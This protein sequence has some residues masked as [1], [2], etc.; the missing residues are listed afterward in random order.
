MKK[1][2][3]FMAVILLTGSLFAQQLQVSPKAHLQQ[4]QSVNTTRATVAT[5]TYSSDVMATNIGYGVPQVLTAV[6]YFPAATMTTYNGNYINQILIGVDPASL[7]SVDV[8]IWTDTSNFAATP[9]YSQTVDVATLTAGWNTII[10]T[11]PYPIDGTP[12]FIGYTANSNDYGMYLDDQ[13]SESNGYG[14]LICD[15]ASWANLSAYGSAFDHNWQIKAVVDDGVAA[16]DVTCTAI[17]VPGAQCGLT[18]S[19]QV[20]VTVQNL[21]SSDLTNAFDLAYTVNGA[22]ATTVA[23]PVPLA[24][25]AT[26][27]VNFTVDMSASG[28]YQI[29]AY[30]TLASDANNT[31]DTIQGV[32]IHTDPAV[33][34]YT[35]HFDVVTGDFVGWFNE[36]V[37]ND[38]SIWGVYQQTGLG[39]ND[40]V[41]PVYQY[42]PT[43]AADDYMYSNC[44]DLLASKTYSL[45][46]WYKVASATYP[47]KMKV[48]IGTSPDYTAMTSQIV[49]LGTISDTVWVESNTTFTVPVDGTYNLGFYAYS[50]ADMWNLFFD[51]VIVDE[52]TNINEVS[53]QT[54]SVYPTLTKGLVHL[55]ISADVEVYSQ[56]GQL[57]QSRKNVQTINLSSLN[58]GIYFVKVSNDNGS[59][60]RKIVLTK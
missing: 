50:D 53:A 40:D 55:S 24:V 22:G 37:N 13:V 39:H 25:G 16:D 9:A 57:V 58:S 2:L 54:I 30:T 27:D 6:A 47:E 28:P 17:S 33:V 20:T 21:G 38:G 10:L 36:D 46:F 56:L 3:S 34:T 48:M 42:N 52:I 19:E 32:T 41:C 51:D 45:D 7:T 1:V 26:V 60:M 44:I 49:D 59:V 5:L 14:D 35:V 4:K 12:L 18:A 15:G 29:D 43:N 23:V 11:T 8:R 31:N